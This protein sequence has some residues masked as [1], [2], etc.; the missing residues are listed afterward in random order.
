MWEEIKNSK[1]D[2]TQ[3]ADNKKSVASPIKSW[4]EVHVDVL[5]G[6]VVKSVHGLV[7]ANLHESNW[8]QV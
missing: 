4:I 6:G 5:L 3:T 8:N 2:K 7:H 1:S